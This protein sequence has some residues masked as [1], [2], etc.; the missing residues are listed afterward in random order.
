M[1]TKDDQRS[2]WR[3][4]EWRVDRSPGRVNK[5]SGTLILSSTGLHPTILMCNLGFQGNILADVYKGVR[6]VVESAA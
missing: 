6:N 3:R 2:G 5:L 1:M 4:D